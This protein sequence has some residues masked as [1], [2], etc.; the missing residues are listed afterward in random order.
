MLS[1]DGIRFGRKVWR[2]ENGVVH[3]LAHIKFSMPSRQLVQSMTPME[4]ENWINRVIEDWDVK[5]G[6]N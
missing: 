5:T 2:D 1:I 6:N 3:H 4:Q